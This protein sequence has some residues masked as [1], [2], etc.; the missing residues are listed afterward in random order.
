MNKSIM[1]EHITHFNIKH[2]L[3]SGQVFRYNQVSE[4]TFLLI[5]KQKVIKICQQEESISPVMHNMTSN[6]FELIWSDYFDL[7]TDYGQITDVL[8]KKDE[9]M[10]KAIMFGN[11]IRILKQDPWE[12]LISFIISQN[13]SIPNIKTCIN[14][15]TNKYGVKIENNDFYEYDVYTFPTPE[16]LSIVTDE[17]LRL[18]KVGFR[19]PYI[20]DA[21]EK[22]ISGDVKL[23]DL[24]EM[25][26]YNA[27]QELLKI[28][29]VGPKIADCIL[30]FAFAKSEVFPTDVWIKRVMEGIYFN[31]E[32]KKPEYIR[33]FAH[34][35]FGD[36]A[37]Y[38][39]QY[40]FYYAR[41]NALFK[42]K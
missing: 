1:L 5:A 9:Y 15:I 18:C 39:Q 32:D 8:M 19:A 29:G 33:D 17:D 37:G 28:R 16:E 13:N 4:N 6:E 26:Y 35:Y 23:A 22:I 20:I 12:M 40:L 42:G 2:I 27:K 3:D 31:G 34:E 14:N 36:L 25:D 41:E 11:G 38:A 10:K 21:C 24:Y 7:K 30:L